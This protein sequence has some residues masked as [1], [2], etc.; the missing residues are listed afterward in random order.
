ML[1]FVR[2][3]CLGSTSTLLFYKIRAALIVRT[4]TASRRH[5]LALLPRSSVRLAFAEKQSHVQYDK[6]NT[7]LYS[8]VYSG[9]CTF[10][11]SER[12][13][14]ASTQLVRIYRSALWRAS[15]AEGLSSAAA[16]IRGF[17]GASVSGAT[18]IS[19]PGLSPVSS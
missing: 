17:E 8:R 1:K 4:I 18:M 10:S 5:C 3:T 6:R 15:A 13:R 11:S 14:A 16:A 2:N 19:G 9:H 12:A 7:T